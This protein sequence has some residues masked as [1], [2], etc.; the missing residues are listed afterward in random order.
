MVIA[1]VND[2][3]VVVF[4]V[5][6]GSMLTSYNKARVALEIPIDNKGWA[7]LLDR[8]RRMWLLGAALIMDGSVPIPTILGGGL[9]YLVL[10]VLAVLTHFTALQRFVRAHRMLTCAGDEEAGG[11]I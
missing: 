10:V 6:T 11:A 4:F 8:P 2:Y 3:W 7:D 5:I 1:W 9:L